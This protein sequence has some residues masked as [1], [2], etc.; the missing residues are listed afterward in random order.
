MGYE[1]VSACVR[2]IDSPHPHPWDHIQ[3]FPFCAPIYQPDTSIV[4]YVPSGLTSSVE[5]LL[6]GQMRRRLRDR[7]SNL[8]ITAAA[9]GLEIELPGAS[10]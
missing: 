2:T 6:A 3:G 4:I 7:G 9:D 8:E 5:G 10:D 1:R